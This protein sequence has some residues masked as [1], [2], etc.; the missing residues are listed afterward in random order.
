MTTD[1]NYVIE[2]AYQRRHVAYLVTMNTSKWSADK[3]IKYR[4]TAVVPAGDAVPANAAHVNYGRALE[5]AGILTKCG[6]IVK[7]VEVVKEVTV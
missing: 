1:P 5:L 2:I 4:V 6:R 7:V 3:K